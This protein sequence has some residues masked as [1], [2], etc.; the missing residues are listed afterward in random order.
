MIGMLR[1]GCRRAGAESFEDV[2]AVRGEG[3]FDDVVRVGDVLAGVPELGGGALGVGLLV[4]EGGDG[5]AESVRGDP[6]EAGVG[7]GLA[8]LAAH[9]LRRQPRAEI[10]ATS[11]D[12]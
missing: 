7:A 5:L 6:F 3:G 8:P 4:D 11:A 1:A 2:G 10:I 9:V 12:S